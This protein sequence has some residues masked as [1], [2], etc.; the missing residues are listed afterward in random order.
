RLMMVFWLSQE[1]ARR[2]KQISYVLFK[3]QLGYYMARLGMRKWLPFKTRIKTDR[4]RHGELTPKLV[5]KIFE[6]VDGSFIKLG[7]LLSLRPDLIPVEYCDELSRLQ[8]KVTPFPGTEA[9]KIIE[10]ELG[11][12]IKSIFTEFDENPVAA[13]S[14]GQV[15]L[16]KLRDGTRVAVKVQRPGIDRT[17]KIDIKLLYRIAH[18]VRKRYGSEFVNPV[19]IVREFERYTED[20][21]NY[22]KEAHNID[23]FHRNFERTR[24]LVIPKVFWN[25]TTGKV[26]TM[27]YIPGKRLT[28]LSKFK[29]A[30]RKRIIN[31]ILEAEFEQI[32]EHGVFHADPHPGNF[33]IKRNGKVALLDFGIVGRMDY[34]IKEHVTEFFISMINRDVDGMVDA[35]VELGATP[36]G[37]DMDAL[38]RDVY[39]RLSKYYGTE[40]EKIKVSDALNDLIRMFR[41]NNIRVIPN[42]VLLTKATVTL[43]SLASRLDPKLNFVEVARPFV[44]RLAKKRLHP[45]HIAERA[46]RKVE[47]MLA[48]AESIPKKTDAFLTELHDTSR[49]LRRI[50]SDISSL[51]VELGRSSNR[52]TLGFLAGTLFI[53]ST[54]LL[55]FQTLKLFGVP[56]LSF[57]GYIIALIVTVSIFF[58]ILGEKKI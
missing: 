50:D 19:E 27:E 23:M 57:L 21:L 51:T 55:P 17:V 52:V 4:F 18:A 54:I 28:D 30:Q 46:K 45:R 38:K 3:H 25:Y 7:Q 32:F 44:N 14:M 2:I 12:Q 47:T 29:P 1:E 22:L 53:A 24:T 56:A 35:A 26:L 11:R 9:V 6:D 13:A 43:E 15:H 37:I 39:D 40:I 20:E 48:F 49:D 34:V 16:A 31:T 42:F 10:K 36:H 58:S 8:D 33:I 41:Q 5:L